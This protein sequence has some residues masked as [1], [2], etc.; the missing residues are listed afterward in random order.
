MILLTVLITLSLAFAG[1]YFLISDRHL[2]LVPPV[3]MTEVKQGNLDVEI[4]AAGELLPIGDNI[5]TIPESFFSDF[6]IDQIAIETLVSDG[7]MVERGELIARLDPTVYEKVKARLEG[8]LADLENK[9]NEITAD[10]VRQLKD[11]KLALQNAGLD[12]EIRKISV[13]QSL[14]DPVSAHERMKLE[15]RKSELSYENA[16]FNLQEKRKN[17]T[18]K[19]DSYPVQIE[20]ISSEIKTKLPGLNKGLD[21][22][23]PWKGV[24]RHI[25]R[26]NKETGITGYVLTPDDRKVAVIEDISRLVSVCLVEEEYFSEVQEGQTVRVYLKSNAEEV[27]ARISRINRLIELHNGKKYFRMETIIENPGNRFLPQQ[28]T[29]NKIILRT[30]EDVVYVPNSAIATN[31]SG[32]YVVLAGGVRR[33]VTCKRINDQYTVV[34]NGLAAGEMIYQDAS[35]G[36]SK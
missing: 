36:N 9:M 24:L 27:E 31:G 25:S 18:E 20:K 33:P 4:I 1:W 6:K 30:L 28:T 34:L 21:I 15:Y 2:A 8:E 35:N 16:L 29:I 11:V 12:L 14:F 26:G 19:Y 32:S 23:S 17:L 13:E 22:Q 7:K 10:S 5:I 3:Q